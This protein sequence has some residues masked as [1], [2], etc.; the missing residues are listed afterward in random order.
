MH[1]ALGKREMARRA[2]ECIPHSERSGSFKE[3]T[4]TSPVSTYNA[5]STHQ[6][7]DDRAH[8]F[9]A[10]RPPQ[11]RLAM[12]VSPQP[13]KTAEPAIIAKASNVDLERSIMGNDEEANLAVEEKGQVS[14]MVR[15]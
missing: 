2:H 4:E 8:H 12:P 15:K 6:F 3:T 13:F 14:P 10:T 1:W 5:A 7:E 9:N 11:V